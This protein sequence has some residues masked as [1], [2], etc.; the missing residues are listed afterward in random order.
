VKLRCLEVEVRSR[1]LPERC[2][3]NGA[4]PPWG[5]TTPLIPAHDRCLLD[6]EPG[7][8]ELL[9]KGC[10]AFAPASRVTIGCPI[11]G[12][13]EGVGCHAVILTALHCH[14]KHY[15]FGLPVP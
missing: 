1:D 9:G 3:L 15:T 14:V 5:N 4:M 8:S 12:G 7:S 2:D 13:D 10:V 6:G 11:K